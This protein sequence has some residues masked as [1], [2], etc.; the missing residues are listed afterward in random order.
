MVTD[1]LFL[2][3]FDVDLVGISLETGFVF[4]APKSSFA[5]FSVADGGDVERFR[6]CPNL[7]PDDDSYSLKAA[8]PPD[9]FDAKTYESKSSSLILP[10]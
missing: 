2:D 7:R 5:V 4:L 8:A 6:K 10:L 3:G 9:G 1:Q